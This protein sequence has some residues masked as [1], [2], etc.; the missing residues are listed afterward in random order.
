MKILMVNKFLYPRGG[1]ESYMLKLGDCLKGLGHE[2]QYFGMFDEKNTVGNNAH[3]Y[4]SNM[5][6]HTSSLKKLA[7]PFKIIYS[8]E[9]KKKI[10]KVLADFKP[11]IVHMNNINF[12]LTP[13]IIDAVKKR[14]IPLVQTVHDF[15][16]VC[17]NHLL[18]DFNN[19]KTCVKCINSNKLHCIKNKCVHKSLVKSIIASAEAYFYK[20]KGTYKKVDKFICPSS[21][22]EVKLLEDKP[23]TFYGKT[24]VIH[25]FAEKHK[26]PDN[27]RSNFDYPYVSFAGRLSAE[28]GVK[29]LAETAK[30][31]PDINF[32]VMGNGPEE[33]AFEGLN[34]VKLTGF[35]TGDELNTNI[36]FSEVIAVPSVCFENC[37]LSI[38]EAQDYGVP[39]V[40][41]NFGGM[42]ELV[43]D[44]ETG[45]LSE[46][47]TP[48]EFS[49]AIRKAID[50]KELL[51]K[52][53]ANCIEESKRAI[54]IEEYCNRVIKIYGE[55]IKENG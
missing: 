31:L 14:N 36:A 16:I 51:L 5:D 39:A 35:L 15:Q 6:F 34:N 2:V 44:N 25:N 54:S 18:Y 1:A 55:L 7:Y 22:L 28:K 17:P 20:I 26:L 27:A 48:K 13:S 52:M 9:A 19:D 45:I 43:R 41:Q 10:E 38:L 30:L 23:D 42:A 11:D 50:N 12:Q 47:A 24:V 53:K 29:L 40:T 21:F 8:S 3:E 49:K 33:K 46:E 37:P 32:V 4:T